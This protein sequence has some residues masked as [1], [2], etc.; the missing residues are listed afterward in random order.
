[1]MHRLARKLRQAN[2][3]ICQWGY[4]STRRTIAFHAANLRYEVDCLAEEGQFERVHFVTH[5]MG[6]IIVRQAFQA[7]H[8]LIVGR[9]VMLAPPNAGS[10][11]ARAGAAIIGR[12]CPVLRELS[13]RPDSYVNRLGPSSLC[14]VGVVAASN[15]W[16]VRRSN[17]HLC[18]QRDHIVVPG[19]HV[20]LPLLRTSAEQTLHFLATGAFRHTDVA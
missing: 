8:P 13:T 11:V 19:D 16:V 1:M 18:T 7:D 4:P 10:H 3:A 9:I 5:S 14:E 15:D 2:Y 12:F 20:R 6:S 17:T